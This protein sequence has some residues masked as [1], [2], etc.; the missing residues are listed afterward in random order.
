[1]DHEPD[2]LEHDKASNVGKSEEQI[3]RERKETKKARRKAEKKE[4]AGKGKKQKLEPGEDE[5]YI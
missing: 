1:V 5:E 3:K 2:V 4:K